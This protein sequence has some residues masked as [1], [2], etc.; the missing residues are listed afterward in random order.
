MRYC[1]GKNP[2]TLAVI[3]LLAALALAGSVTAGEAMEQDQAKAL[4]DTGRILPLATIIEQAKKIHAGRVVGAELERDSTGY[5]YEI[6]IADDDGTLWE[7]KFDAASG[8][9]IESERER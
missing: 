3:S 1:P 9:L 7:M 2:V 4:R 5:V 6:L 8:A